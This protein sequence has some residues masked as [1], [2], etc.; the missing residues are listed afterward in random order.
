MTHIYYQITPIYS[1]YNAKDAVTEYLLE[2]DY[3][4]KDDTSYD[5]PTL[6]NDALLRLGNYL[7]NEDVKIS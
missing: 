2:Y 7:L 6:L 4:I 3:I 1:S 5:W